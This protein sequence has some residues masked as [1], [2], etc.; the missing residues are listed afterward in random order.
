MTRTLPRP[1]CADCAAG[2]KH[3]HPAEAVRCRGC[4]VPIAETDHPVLG[5]SWSDVNEGVSCPSM[6]AAHEPGR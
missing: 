2:V 5:K 3:A 6:L 1:E 4:G